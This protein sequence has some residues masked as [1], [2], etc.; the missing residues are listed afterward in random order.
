MTSEPAFRAHFARDPRHFG[1]ESIE[2]VD[3]R[4]DRVFEREDLAAHVDRD[5][6]REIA[7]S[8]GRRDLSD[9]AHLVG[10]I[11]AHRVD[12]VGKVLPCSRDAGHKRLPAEFSLRSDLASDS[13]HFGREGPELVD[14]RIDGLLELKNF[15][16]DVDSDLLREVAV[17]NRNGDFGDVANL[18]GQV[19][20]HRVDAFGQIPPN[21]GDFANLRLTAQFSV[22]ANF[23]GDARDL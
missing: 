6:A 11:A 9:V 17:R 18:A 7:P 15:A 21:P 8:D 13:G 1:R 2:L 19:A 14:H 16:S 10:Q 12:A 20:R 23:A 4:V 3:H 5:L 22:S